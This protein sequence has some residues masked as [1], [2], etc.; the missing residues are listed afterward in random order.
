MATENAAGEELD[1]RVRLRGEMRDKYE[2][3]KNAKGI[4]A[5]SELVRLLVSEEYMRLKKDFGQ[6][7]G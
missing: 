3:V 6:N 4:E 2:K 7:F 5:D 1:I